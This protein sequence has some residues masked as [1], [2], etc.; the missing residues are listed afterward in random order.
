MVVIRNGM[1]GAIGMEK[2]AVEILPTESVTCAVNVEVPLLR[3]VPVMAPLL[4]SVN[5]FG[6]EPVNENE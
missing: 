4:L 2:E 1:Y 5:P 3:G 6:S